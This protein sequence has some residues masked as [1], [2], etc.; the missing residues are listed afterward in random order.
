MIL[1]KKNNI[2]VA[3]A[4]DLTKELKTSWDKTYLGVFTDYHRVIHGELP[5]KMESLY[6]GRNYKRRSKLKPRLIADIFKDLVAYTSHT[7]FAKN[8]AFEFIPFEKNDIDGAKRANQLVRYSWLRTNVKL[9]AKSIIRDAATLGGGFGR[10]EQYTDWRFRP[11]TLVNGV[12]QYDE[13]TGLPTSGYDILYRGGKLVRMCTE[14]V[15]PENVNCFENIGACPVV[16]TLPLSKI[17]AE[18]QNE[19]GLYYNYRNN[20]KKIKRVDFENP[21]QEYISTTEHSNT[22]YRIKDFPVKVAEIWQRMRY[23][24]DD[25]ATWYCITIAN[26]DSGTPLVIRFARD[27]MGTGT[28]PFVFCRIFPRDDRMFGDAI[29]EML[30]DLFLEK[31]HKKNQ[32]IDF[33]NFMLAVHGTV[34]GKRGQ[35]ATDNLIFKMGK[36]IQLR[37]GQP[38]DLYTVT[39]PTEAIGATIQEES[40]IDKEAAEAMASNKIT[41]GRD[42]SR[43]EAATTN[44]IIDENAKIRQTEP[45]S[46]IE[47]TLVK[48][49][50]NAYLMQCQLYMPQNMR[51]RIMGNDNKYDWVNV[52]RKDILG[53]YDIMCRASTEILP[54]ALKQSNYNAMVQTYGQ[55]LGQS[56]DWVEIFKEHAELNEM[57]NAHKWIKDASYIEADIKREED[58]MVAMGQPW[59]ALNHEP[60]IQH[61]NSHADLLNDLYTENPDNPAVMA[62]ENHIQQHQKLLSIQQGQ[63]QVG[64][65]PRADNMG[66]YLNNT[67][68]TM[69]P[70]VAGR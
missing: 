32:R 58:F 10:I 26:Y 44:A 48:P 40:I 23:G 69:S 24:K 13:G 50:A 62:L 70:K 56:L 11:R 59:I 35:I 36:F 49:V 41:S 63:Q 68:S 43:R 37:N 60:H 33:I 15:Y 5:Q 38:K 46:N 55:I 64:G 25:V 17:Q 16:M 19:R 52:E 57:P 28:H 7:L 34:F 65:Q 1:I 61:L 20:V 39:L 30:M 3:D 42:P 45:I 18:S 31:F 9:V 51:V 53:R 47:E 6:N 67:S 4:I 29:P 54:R 66:E 2:V 21:E 14:T 22:N 8:S 12:E 27:P